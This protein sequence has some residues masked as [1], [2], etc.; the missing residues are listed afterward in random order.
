VQRHKELQRLLVLQAIEQLEAGQLLQH[1]M[2][3]WQGQQQHGQVP[4]LASSSSSSTALQH[5]YC[6][7]LLAAVW[8]CTVQQVVV[9]QQASHLLRNHSSLLPHPVLE[10]P[11][12]AVQLAA[13]ARQW[14]SSRLYQS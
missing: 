13:A 12:Q 4:S 11:G 9:Q 2:Q 8:A 10:R 7:L 1:R 14:A 6:Q 3:A 5:L